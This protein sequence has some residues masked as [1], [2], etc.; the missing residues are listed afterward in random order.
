MLF[1][2]VGICN[3][4]IGKILKFSRIVR[5]YFWIR[6]VKLARSHDIN[7]LELFKPNY[8]CLSKKIERTKLCKI[9]IQYSNLEYGKALRFKYWFIV[10]NIGCRSHTWLTSLKH[11]L[12]ERQ[13][14]QVEPVAWKSVELFLT[15]FIIYFEKLT[16]TRKKWR[17]KLKVRASSSFNVN[18]NEQRLLILLHLSL[19]RT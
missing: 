13:E 4:S 11:I 18:I 15:T 14:H 17:M 6:K 10:T 9:P 19:M 3:K 2:L 8:Y 16:K 1:F 12:S 7:S 5:T